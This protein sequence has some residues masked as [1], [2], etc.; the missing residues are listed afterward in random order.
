MGNPETPFTQL[1]KKY[2]VKKCYYAHLH[3]KSIYGA[4]QGNVDGI[5]YKLVSADALKF[6]PYKIEIGD[7]T[8]K[9]R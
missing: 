4:V 6:C 7:N 2:G 5:E 1:L 9:S 8:T 3:G